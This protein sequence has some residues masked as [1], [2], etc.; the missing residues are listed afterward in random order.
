MT[1]FGPLSTIRLD[2]AKIDFFTEAMNVSRLN[3]L[4]IWSGHQRVAAGLSVS[5]IYYVICYRTLILPVFALP[6]F[7]RMVK[8]RLY[9]ICNKLFLPKETKV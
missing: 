7:F 6:D 5:L 3:V 9:H 4:K 1:N 2:N 8:V